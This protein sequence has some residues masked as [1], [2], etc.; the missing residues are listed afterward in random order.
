MATTQC[1]HD[2][3][4]FELMNLLCC[5]IISWHVPA[6]IQFVTMLQQSVSCNYN[7]LNTSISV[8]II[9]IVCG[10]NTDHQVALH[11]T[12]SRDVLQQQLL[13]EAARLYLGEVHWTRRN[14]CTLLWYVCLSTS[15]ATFEVQVL[16]HQLSIVRVHS[17]SVLDNA[18]NT[19]GLTMYTGLPSW[20]ALQPDLYMASF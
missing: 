18:L 7:V 15:S 12:I 9:V 5:L 4:T 14:H 20:L 10:L 8:L 3:C 11:S 1:E 16:R 6:R 2:E 19:V 13:I 17:H